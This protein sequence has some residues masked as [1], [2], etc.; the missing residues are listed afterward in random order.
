MKNVLS[1][2][3][4]IRRL[5]SVPETFCGHLASARYPARPGEGDMEMDCLVL[6]SQ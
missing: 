4:S 3:I 2:I 5:A 6:A 1:H